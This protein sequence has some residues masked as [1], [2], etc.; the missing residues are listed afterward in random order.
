MLK[1]LSS[2]ENN[3]SERVN[4]DPNIDYINLR[5]V[6]IEG[7]NKIY[8]P[9]KKWNKDA[10]GMYCAGRKVLTSNLIFIYKRHKET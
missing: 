7:M 8:C 9:A 3:G 2:T 5:K 10:P 1:V 6:Q 4:Y